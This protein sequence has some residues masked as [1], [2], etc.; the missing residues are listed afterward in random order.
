MESRQVFLEALIEA[1]TEELQR[2]VYEGSRI[3]STFE[4]YVEASEEPSPDL[5]CTLSSE[6]PSTLAHTPGPVAGPP[7]GIATPNHI[8]FTPRKRGPTAEL[9]RPSPYSSRL[10]LRDEDHGNYAQ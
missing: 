8:A 5:D 10:H 3:D 6:T 9:T 7:V 2:N 1:A 4:L